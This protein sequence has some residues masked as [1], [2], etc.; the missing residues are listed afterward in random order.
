MITRKNV[1]NSYKDQLQRTQ[2][3]FL[4][5]AGKTELS[6]DDVSSNWS[7]VVDF[8][9]A[10]SPERNEDAVAEIMN[11]LSKQEVQKVNPVGKEVSLVIKRFSSY[12]FMKSIL[13]I[14]F[15]V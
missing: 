8:T 11:G 2:G 7:K 4:L 10:T 5:P 14:F 9:N 6:I 1:L 3:S 15:A 13:C 12:L